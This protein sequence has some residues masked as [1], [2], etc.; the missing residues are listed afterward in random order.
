MSILKL[1]GDKE[2]RTELVGHIARLNAIH[3]SPAHMQRLMHQLLKAPTRTLR[4]AA[5]DYYLSLLQ[6]LIDSV[7]KE[8]IRNMFYFTGQERS[9][10]QLRTPL[11]TTAPGLAWTGNIRLER[12]GA[13]RN[14][15][16][17]SFL[18]VKPNNVK[19]VEL[20]THER[21]LVYR[22]VN[23]YK[24]DNSTLVTLS[25]IELSED[26]WHHITM[27]HFD[28]ELIVCVDKMIQR[29]EV[30][31]QCFPRKYNTATIGTATDPSTM[32]QQSLF[33]GEMSALYF[34]VPSAA[35]KDAMSDLVYR[36]AYLPFVYKNE[37]A[38]VDDNIL[39][40]FPEM[41]Q[42][43]GLKY[44]KR[45]FV[46]STFFIL[47]PKVRLSYRDNSRIVQRLQQNYAGGPG[48]NPRTHHECRGLPP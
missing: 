42:C 33:F 15:C 14:Q 8:S 28:K 18:R 2:F 12:G 34:F 29:A 7:S 13:D 30:G 11:I 38:A 32:H 10:I 31:M 6:V 26:T 41:A 36:G 5:E 20:Y 17:F 39:Y 35:F 45:E 19:G 43:K 40:A 47:D 24:G 21:K 16:I 4:P 37:V 46:A 25:N 27:L 23:L 44:V 1:T 9:F 3:T 48:A 22:M